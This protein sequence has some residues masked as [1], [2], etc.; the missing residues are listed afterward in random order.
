[1]QEV[2]NAITLA[3][4][5]SDFV[6]A[7]CPEGTN[8]IGGGGV[9]EGGYIFF[10]ARSEA[11]NGWEVGGDNLDTMTSHGLVAVAYCSPNV[12]VSS[13]AFSSPRALQTWRT[14]VAENVRNS[15]RGR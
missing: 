10:E 2:V 8:P 15:R 1:V 14:A 7:V 5:T 13:Q 4:E 11:G 6:T 12:A 9:S 3:P